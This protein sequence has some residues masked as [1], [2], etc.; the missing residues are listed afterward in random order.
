MET[1]YGHVMGN[2]PVIKSLATLAFDS[3]RGE[4]FREE[5]L[6]ALKI[7]NDKQVSLKKFKGEWAGASGI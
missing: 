1:S 5:L 6:L 4:H 2:F 7:V 3:R